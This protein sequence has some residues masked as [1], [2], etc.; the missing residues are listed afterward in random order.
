VT[1]VTCSPK[2]VHTAAELDGDANPRTS[3]AS[4]SE[5]SIQI[6]QTSL[7]DVSSKLNEPSLALNDQ[8]IE[9]L[10]KLT[11]KLMERPPNTLFTNYR[12]PGTRGV[13]QS[14]G[15]NPA[16]YHFINRSFRLRYLGCHVLRCFLSFETSKLLITLNINLRRLST[17]ASSSPLQPSTRS[18]TAHDIKRDDAA[19]EEGHHQGA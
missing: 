4:A 12:S 14:L 15:A 5:C 9:I 7:R 3:V 8:T 11:E 16:S 6:N 19:Q 13:E 18:R 10:A 17:H 2:C 1:R